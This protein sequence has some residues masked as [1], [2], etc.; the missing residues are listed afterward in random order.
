MANEFKVRKGLI[1]QGSGSTGDETLLDVQGN[2][3]QL[4]SV[5]DSL[6]GDIFTVSDISG[7]PIL[8]VSSSGIVE[9]GTFGNY[10]LIVNGTNITSSGNISASGFV[11]ADGFTVD[12]HLALQ[13]SGNTG[14]VFSG[15]TSTAI[16]IGRSNDPNKNISLWGPVTASGNISAS[17]AIYA[18]NITASGDLTINGFSSVSASLVTALAGSTPSG[19][20]S[21]SVLSSATQGTALLTTNGVAGTTVDLGLEETDDVIFGHISASNITSSGNISASGTG[22]FMFLDI[23]K[24]GTSGYRNYITGSVGILGGSSTVSSLYIQ[25]GSGGGGNSALYLKAGSGNAKPTLYI[26]NGG[27]KEGIYT[28]AGSSGLAIIAKGNISA[29]GN[30]VKGSNEIDINDGGAI[31]IT[32]SDDKDVIINQ[33]ENNNVGLSIKDNGTSGTIF[34]IA[35]N[36]G[37]VT[38]SGN[39]SSSGTMFCNNLYLE[40]QRILY[41]NDDI[42]LPDTGLNVAGGAITAS[43][44]ISSSVASK[45]QNF[46]H[47]EPAMGST[48]LISPH[49][50]VTPLSDHTLTVGGSIKSQEGGT[51]NIVALANGHVTASGNISASGNVLAGSVY[52]KNVFADNTYRINDSGGTSRHYIIR[53][54]NSISLGNTNFAH[55]TLT[56][57]LSSS[58]NISLKG[59]ISASTNGNHYFGGVINNNQIEGLSARSLNMSNVGSIAAAGND[60]GIRFTN[61]YDTAIGDVDEAS[62]GTRIEVKDSNQT[63]SFL[64]GHVT[65]SNNISA[66]GAIYAKNITASGDLTIAG[67]SSVSASLVTALAGSTPSGTVSA[68][69]LSSPAQGKAQLT[70]NGVAATAVDLGL[71]TTDSPTFAG[72]SLNDGNLTNVGQ[73]NC[74]NIS[75]DATGGDTQISI[76]GTSI[77]IDCGSST[78]I[79]AT[80]TTIHNSVPTRVYNLTASFGANGEGTISASANISGKSISVGGD[81]YGN[82]SLFGSGSGT[83]ISG[84]DSSAQIRVKGGQKMVFSG[85]TLSAGNVT[86]QNI[87][88]FFVDTNITASGN[89]SSSAKI[90][91]D[92][93][94]VDGYL[95]LN[96]DGSTQGRVF[97]DTSITSIQIGRNG[98]P[99][100]NIELL[101]P[102]TASGNIS[103]SGNLTS[104]GVYAHGNM[105]A[106]GQ[107]SGNG[108]GSSAFITCDLF[109]NVGHNILAGHQI[110]AGS[111]LEATTHVTA[112]ENGT[113]GGCLGV[114]TAVPSNVNG[115]IR[116]TNDVIAYYSSD[117]RLKDNI[118][119]L[120][121]S[122]DKIN[123]IR[124]VEFDWIK[125]EGIHD[126]EGHDIGVIAQE[127]EKVFPEVVQT[128]EN[129]YKAVKYDKLTAVLISA[130]KEL[131]EEIE[132]LKKK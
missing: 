95:A 8:N 132:E 55:T 116:A 87:D 35:G 34:S 53:Y 10:G 125:K 122:V 109:A 66:S 19:T 37:H 128:R 36:Y 81:I 25:Q 32:P 38:A 46:H 44:N 3:G 24:N 65:A 39:I 115:L 92:Q 76:T 94:N 119:E 104:S 14:R 52:C 110:K 96:T 90:F 59:V 26:E 123:Q 64:A 105:S 107:I 80:P 17:G 99:T 54:G 108:I 21:A 31:G 7:I 48:V 30:I 118:R 33:G 45:L 112:S 27:T 91:A 117:E 11:Y 16:E 89:I 67:F 84:T 98:S 4:F 72:L 40:N 77:E 75:D 131:K 42:T 2:Q 29:S 1:V 129:G 58:G 111:Y 63:I 50:A 51:T 43:G 6:I 114:G 28:E 88:E 85:H 73:I 20:V 78:I 56:G 97:P 126:N 62:F 130:I 12:S 61:N 82:V 41:T 49:N 101:G 18:K 57:S 71:E 120:S 113:I 5:T 103:A 100:K 102:V 69:V 124:G 93:Y 22:S 127:I 15:T 121:G 68:S 106:S 47:I 79:S 13:T 83:Y 60:P 23:G 74:D 86:F 70:T 9:A